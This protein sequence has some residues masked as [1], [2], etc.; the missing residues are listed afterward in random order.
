MSWSI[1]LIGKPD[2]IVKALHEQ[3][4]KLNGQSKEE[5]DVALPN[6]EN[7]VKQNYDSTGVLVLSFVASGHAYKTTNGE[8][9][10]SNC[11][12]EIKHVPGRLV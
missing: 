5:F 10:H 2:N 3:S 6:L 11:L 7:L 12:V 4:E 8:T 9:S 1:A